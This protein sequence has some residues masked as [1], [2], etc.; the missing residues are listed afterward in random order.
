MLSTK[1]FV[2]LDRSGSM[3]SCKNDTIGGFNTFVKNQKDI[4]ADT[5]FLSLYQFDHEYLISFEN[6]PIS[7]VENLNQETFTPRG[8]TALLDAIGRT[9]NSIQA[10]K[11][12]TIIVVII[13]DGEENASHEFSKDKINK[14]I[15]EKKELGWEFVFLGANQDAIKS[16]ANIGIG[17]NSSLTYSANKSKEAWT[18]VSAAIERTRS[19]PMAARSAIAFTSEERNTSID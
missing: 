19:T 13:T 12:E 5:A 16:A 4:K 9:I 18:S 2:V 7:Q 1:I 10:N 15:N 8:N 3:D 11:D 14:M 6:K 17:P